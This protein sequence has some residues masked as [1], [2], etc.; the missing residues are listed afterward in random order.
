LTEASAAL[1]NGGQELPAFTLTPNDGTV[2]GEAA[3]YDPSVTLVNDAPEITITATNNFTEEQASADDVVAS[4][5]TS[6][7]EGDTVSVTL[8]DTTNYAL[9]G[10]VNV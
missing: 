9:D 7:E 1:V 6:D 4:Y 2:D 8:S 5:T 10:N 3:S